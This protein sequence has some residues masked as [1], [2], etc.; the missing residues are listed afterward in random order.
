[1]A[2]AIGLMHESTGE[3][4]RRRLV[5]WKPSRSRRSLK[6]SMLAGASSDSDSDGGG[7]GSG[8]SSSD[9]PIAAEAAG[10]SS[11]AA[12]GPSSAAAAGPSATAAEPA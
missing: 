7:G 2:E 5:V 4:H 1:M 8:G 11:A 10:P 6:P 3:A 12:A 9:S